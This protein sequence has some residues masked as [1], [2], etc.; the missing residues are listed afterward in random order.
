MRIPPHPTSRRMRYPARKKMNRQL[1]MDCKETL[2]EMSNILG[3]VL[4][5][6][7]NQSQA[8]EIMGITSNDFSKNLRSSF[9]P[10]IKKNHY[11]TESMINEILDDLETPCEKL[12]KNIFGVHPENRMLIMETEI[13]NDFIQVV[14]KSLTDR[15]YTIVNLI[16]GLEENRNDTQTSTL[17][18][19][20]KELGVT[21]ERVRQIH[22]KALRKLRNPKI[23]RQLCPNFKQYSDTIDEID[24]FNRMNGNL[25]KQY[26]DLMSKLRWMKFQN[27]M[28]I[29]YKNLE[30]ECSFT[31][32]LS[33]C[34]GFPENWIMA[35]SNVGI[36]NV[37][38]LLDADEELLKQAAKDSGLRLAELYEFCGKNKCLPL[39]IK[40]NLDEP[41]ESLELSVRSYNA[42][43]KNNI[44]TI[45]D[46]SGITVRELKNIR[47]LGQRSVDEI[48]SRLKE[49]YN[50][51]LY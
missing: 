1:I 16:Y 9:V 42:L 37:F 44:R 30:K 6:E 27:K 41:I 43:I 17:S 28:V 35:L 45:R 48:C 18:Q 2:D 14:K 4:N 29:S 26:E 19:T 8:A 5:R 15:E 11:I 25:E 38:Q 31:P 50:I 13:Q 49:K 36:M 46:L 24:C 32:H 3:R 23:L 10:Y 12:A 21:T 40:T 33:D 51:V 34:P 7:L 20:A 47:C 22:A 39:F